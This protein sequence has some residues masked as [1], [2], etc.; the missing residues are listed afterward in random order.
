[1][2]IHHTGQPPLGAVVYELEKLRCNL[3]G[4][5]FTA[6]A[7]EGVGE[8]KYDAQSAVSFLQG[9]VTRKI[10]RFFRGNWIYF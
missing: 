7:P 10:S 6:P 5:I 2:S 3:C 1:V 4:E 8:D 9:C